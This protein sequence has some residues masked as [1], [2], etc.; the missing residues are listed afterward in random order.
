M[1]DSSSRENKAEAVCPSLG[2]NYDTP[3]SI[4]PK[5][6]LYYSLQR[7]F[8]YGNRPQLLK[9]NALIK[10]ASYRLNGH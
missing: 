2:I 5:Y 9:S 3:V 10:R 1:S 6:C 7:S 8:I 4:Q